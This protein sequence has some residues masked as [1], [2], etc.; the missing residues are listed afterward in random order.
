M[1]IVS[2]NVG[3]ES[4]LA[5]IGGGKITTGINKVPISG[6]VSVG[7]L[8]LAEDAV[9][10]T[11]SHGGVDQAVYLYRQEDYE[12]W[13]AALGREV[14]AGSFGEN[15]TVAGLP[16]PY[17]CVGDEIVLPN[18]RL[19]ATAPR[20]PCNT[21]AAKMGDK[22]FPKKFIKAQLPGIYCRVLEVGHVTVGDIFSIAAYEG[23][24]ITTVEFFSDWLSNVSQEQ[25][26]RYLKVPIDIRSRRVM[27][28][29]MRVGIT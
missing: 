2:V 19:Q 17:L 25:L 8:G 29:K 1:H 23:D 15:L 6:A 10:D 14:V 5:R 22:L 7:D 11:K 16:D 9:C 12:F 4:V 3:K 13:S 24:R 28:E 20:I 21:L 26:K 27:E 18:L